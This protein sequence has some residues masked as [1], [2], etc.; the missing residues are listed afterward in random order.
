MSKRQRESVVTG[1]QYLIGCRDCQPWRP[2]AFDDEESRDAWIRGHDDKHRIELGLRTFLRPGVLANNHPAE[3][4]LRH[5]WRWYWVERGQ[6]I[7]PIMHVPLPRDGVLHDVHVFPS[8][9]LMERALQGRWLQYTPDDINARGYALTMGRGLPPIREDMNIDPTFGSTVVHRYEATAIFTTRPLR[10]GAY[11]M[12][13][14]SHADLD[15]AILKRAEYPG[16]A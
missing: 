15:L 5:A 16:G 8:A 9:T 12:S 1:I 6:L 3:P 4:M 2:I 14:D 10:T 11:D 7:S 13:V